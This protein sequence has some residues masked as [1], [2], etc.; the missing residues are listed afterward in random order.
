MQFQIMIFNYYIKQKNISM[1]LYTLL[2]S[3]LTIAAL[4]F[5]RLFIQIPLKWLFPK[6]KFEKLD[7][8]IDQFS[9]PY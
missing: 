5:L 3:I 7:S 6:K 2:L 8:K 4:F 9:L 1:R